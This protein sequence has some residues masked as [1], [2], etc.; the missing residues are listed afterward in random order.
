MFRYYII[1]SA[2]ALVPENE[3]RH[4]RGCGD[5]ATPVNCEYAVAFGMPSDC[6]NFDA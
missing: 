3:Y 1:G 4:T 6:A 5:V 2:G